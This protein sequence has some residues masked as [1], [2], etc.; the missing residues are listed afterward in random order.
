MI[1]SGSAPEVQIFRADPRLQA[2]ARFAR[3]VG[4]EPEVGIFDSRES[5]FGAAR[6]LRD[7]GIPSERIELLLPG[8]QAE[9]E[10]SVPTDEAEQPGVGRAL[11]GVAGGAIGAS[12]GLGVGAAVA[13][14]MLPGVGAVT[15]IGLAA[16]ALFG[17][18]GAAAGV[19]A[20]GELEDRSYRGLPRDELYLY[21]DA[22]AHGRAVLFATPQ[23][24]EQVEAVRS[25]MV[26]TGAVS[27]DAARGS[28]WIG[29]RD[30][31][32]AHYEASPSREPFHAVEG[33][34]RRGYLAGLTGKPAPEGE[35]RSTA[36][37]D[38]YR[39][40][41]ER[42]RSRNRAETTASAR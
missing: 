34:Y 15:A 36:E 41:F 23:S 27:L 24:E 40:G 35:L 28:F 8:H 17:A 2:G 26:A 1:G 18:G 12:V 31:E 38:A 21:E 22:L 11:G 37:K 3:S 32:K 30:A 19:A 29:I 16:A 4:V 13:S 9:A 25:V 10:S 20:G 6:A 42:A 7:R 5:A 33:A 14:L 39:A